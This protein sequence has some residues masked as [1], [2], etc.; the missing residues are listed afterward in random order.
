M[1]IEYTSGQADV[2]LTGEHINALRWYKKTDTLI[3]DDLWEV[4]ENNIDETPEDLFNLLKLYYKNKTVRSR[5][6]ISF[7]RQ[8]GRIEITNKSIIFPNILIIKNE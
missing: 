4:V 1:T 8:S 3:I 5:A 2:D 6:E 7:D